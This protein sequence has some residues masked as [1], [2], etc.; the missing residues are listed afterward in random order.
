MLTIQYTMRPY[1]D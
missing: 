1:I